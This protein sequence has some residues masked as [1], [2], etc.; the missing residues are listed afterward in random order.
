MSNGQKFGIIFIW[1]VVGIAVLKL[2]PLTVTFISGGLY[3]LLG[4]H[5]RDKGKDK[6]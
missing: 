4:M 6:K 1:M 3:F 2:A 5:I